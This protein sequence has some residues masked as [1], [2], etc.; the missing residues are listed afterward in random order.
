[1][2][3]TFKSRT[4]A[5]LEPTDLCQTFR[6]THQRAVVATWTQ[7]WNFDRL[8]AQRLDCVIAAR[9]RI[10]SYVWNCVMATWRRFA[11][12]DAFQ[13]GFLFH[14]R[15]RD[16][17]VWRHELMPQIN[18]LYININDRCICYIGL[19]LLSSSSISWSNPH[20][21]PPLHP[22]LHSHRKRGRAYSYDII[23]IHQ[24]LKSNIS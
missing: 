23:T 4:W 1:M 17:S 11:T 6:P 21:P 10:A 19:I 20:P 3:V 13:P 5:L 18:I 22:P 16:S 24:R 8:Q 2:Q 12:S 9:G 15:L 14:L 7:M